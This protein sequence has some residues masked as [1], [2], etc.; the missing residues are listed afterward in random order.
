MEK[1]VAKRKSENF[2]GIHR[3]CVVDYLE[4]LLMPQIFRGSRAPS[5]PLAR[6]SGKN[7]LTTFTTNT[8]SKWTVGLWTPP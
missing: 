8:V 6:N 2:P 1:R 4:S 3:S 7:S 5:R